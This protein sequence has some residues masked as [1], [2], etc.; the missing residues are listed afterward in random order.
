[1]LAVAMSTILWSVLGVLLLGIFLTR[2]FSK[3]T[4]AIT[5]ALIAFGTNLY[6]YTS[7]EPGMSHPFVFF[8]FSAILYLTERW[9]ATQRPRYL[10]LI[11]LTLGWI[12]IS[13]PTGLLIALIPLLW[14]V[15]NGA[16]L[17]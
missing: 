11:G 12:T 7:I 3:N 9:Y 16:D 15:G 5:L 13:R 14:M 4:A 10:Y 1:Q 8:L 17:S 6:C 2:L